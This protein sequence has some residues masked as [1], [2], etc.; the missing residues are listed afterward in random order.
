MAAI[1]ASDVT[2]TLLDRII[3]GRQRQNLLRLT[4]GN[5]ALTYPS[6]GVPMPAASALGLRTIKAVQ[7]IGDTSTPGTSWGWDYT[8]NTLRATRTGHIPPVIVEEAVTLTSHVGTL[9]YKPAYII[10]AVGTISATVTPLKPIPASIAPATTQMAVNFST[11]VVTCF[12]TDAVSA[13]KVSYIPQQ[14]SGPFS[15]DNLVVDEAITLSTGGVNT[16]FRAATMQYCYQTTATAARL[17]FNNQTAASGRPKLDMVNS[18]ATTFTAHSDN[19]A[20]VALVTYL[21][22]AGFADNVGVTFIDQATVSLSSQVVEFGKTAGNLTPGLYI[23]GFGGQL[24]TVETTNFIQNYLGDSSVTAAAGIV[25]Y[26][27]AKQKL[28][29]AE[30]TP[31]TSIQDVPFLFLSSLYQ[32]QAY[33]AELTINDA[34]AATTLYCF[35]FG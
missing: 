21:K 10:C 17:P 11:G 32:P 1:A 18:T 34:P 16:A 9:K 7:V 5:S 22:Y 3:T 23:P 29:T 15:A 31:Q 14:S 13:M 30:T 33:I 4:F 8:N 24:V 26:E 25:K 28:T 6:G 27:I 20:K 12:A 19:N 2:V 35:C